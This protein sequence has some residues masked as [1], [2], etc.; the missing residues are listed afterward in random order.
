MIVLDP[1]GSFG[2]FEPIRLRGDGDHVL[3]PPAWGPLSTR[4][5]AGAYV[6]SAHV[7]GGGGALPW[8]TPRRGGLDGHNRGQAA[9]C[10][11]TE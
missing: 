8:D 11:N 10:S 1:Y 4:G 2:S 7:A 3:D 5:H 6:D 9:E